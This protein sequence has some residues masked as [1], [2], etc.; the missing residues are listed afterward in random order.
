[1]KKLLVPVLVVLVLSGCVGMKTASVQ[2]NFDDA[3]FQPDQ[4]DNNEVYGKIDP[5]AAEKREIQAR[6]AVQNRTTRSYGQSYSDRMRNF[7]SSNNSM[8]PLMSPMVVY[9]PWMNSASMFYGYNPY[10]SP[11]MG[12]GMNNP[13]GMMGYNPYG[14]NSFGCSN[15]FG[16]YD[17][18]GYN[19]FGYGNSWMYWNQV[20]NP[21]MYGNSWGGSNSSNSNWTGGWNNNSKS[22]NTY[23][24][25]GPRRS[26]YNSGMSTGSN[27]GSSGSGSSGSSG[28]SAGSGGRQTTW[29]TTNSGNSAGS[30]GTTGG[31][32]R[33]TTWGSSSGS[34]SSSSSGSGTSS[35]STSNGSSGSSGRRR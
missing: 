34:S 27:S 28:T 14:F 6:L 1:M 31:G 23:T 9:N 17:P 24:P 19:N 2:K 32:S 11:Y 21:Y 12:M 5:S 20:N 7:R 22:G 33:Q 3:Y 25:Q 4:I 8:Q 15:Y 18:Y 35:G 10:Y 26:T 13:Y 16:Y 30:S 29:G